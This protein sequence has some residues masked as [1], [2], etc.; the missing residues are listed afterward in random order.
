M[1]SVSR[2]EYHGAER[3]IALVVYNFNNIFLRGLR[4]PSA[5]FLRHCII[6]VSNYSV[7]IVTVNNGITGIYHF[8]GRIGESDECSGI[9]SFL[10][11]DEAS[12]ITGETIVVAGGAQS[13]L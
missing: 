11:S 9:V 4:F 3:R 8:S 10:S 2:K 13:R 1:T 6:T 7:Q 12:Y 5:I